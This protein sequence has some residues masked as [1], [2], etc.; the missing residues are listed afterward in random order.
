MQRHLIIEKLWFWRPQKVSP[1]L[2][3]FYQSFFAVKLHLLLFSFYLSVHWMMFLDLCFNKSSIYCS[4]KFSD[5]LKS[6]SLKLQINLLSGA[7]ANIRF[8]NHW[9]SAFVANKWFNIGSGKRKRSPDVLMFNGHFMFQLLWPINKIKSSAQR[10]W[11]NVKMK[12]PVK[13][14]GKRFKLQFGC[15]WKIYVSE[16]KNLMPETCRYEKS[17]SIK[18]PTRFSTRKNVPFLQRIK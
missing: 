11:W 7:P 10:A 12:N 2:I 9:T 17:S 4:R 13:G 6:Q 3:H 18:T 16:S 1:K 8:N 15:S 14:S 5:K